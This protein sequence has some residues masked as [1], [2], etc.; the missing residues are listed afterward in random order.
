MSW[1][2]FLVAWASGTL[3]VTLGRWFWAWQARRRTNG[4]YG[5]KQAKKPEDKVAKSAKA[6]KT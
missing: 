5:L 1:K 2:A 4:G 6:K 3:G